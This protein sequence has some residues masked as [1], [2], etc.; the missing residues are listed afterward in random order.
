MP[1]ATTIMGVDPGTREMGIAI[2]RG[3]SLIACGVHTLRNGDRPHDVIAQ[4]RRILLSYIGE[5]GPG[6]VGIEKPLLHPTKRAALVSVIVEELRARSRE[7][8]LHVMEVSPRD[9]RGIVVGDRCAKKLDVAKALVKRFPELRSKLPKAPKR[10]A[11]GFRPRDKYWLHMFD[12]LAVAVVLFNS[13]ESQK[14]R[15]V[16]THEVYP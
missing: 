1:Y 6:L 3:Q 12:A 13:Y 15:L 2:L 5:Y 14:L 7:L 8:G 11:L 4:A 10:S 16:P 9:A